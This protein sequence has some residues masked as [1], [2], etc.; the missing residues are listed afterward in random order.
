[1][2]DRDTR[3]KNAIQELESTRRDLGEAREGAAANAA[4]L[5]QER[6]ALSL[7][8]ARTNELH[9]LGVDMERE[10]TAMLKGLLD[11][12]I[13]FILMC[14]LRSFFCCHACSAPRVVGNY[15]RYGSDTAIHGAAAA[16]AAVSLGLFSSLTVQ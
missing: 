5:E 4:A 13:F 11:F 12:F 14:D 7:S 3:L 2:Q 9:K 1:M 8:R 16:A 15:H 6:E 10:L